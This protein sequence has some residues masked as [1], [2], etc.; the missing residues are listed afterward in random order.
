MAAVPRL[1]TAI[2]PEELRG[3]VTLVPVINE[4]AF[5]GGHRTA[6]DGLDLA[7]TCPGRPA[8]SITGQ[9]AFSLPHLI[10]AAYLY[11]DLHTGGTRLTV[12]P[13]SGY[14]L[15]RNDDVLAKQR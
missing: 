2:K 8:G 7:R 14:M 1:M 3:R 10:R 11:I 13:L 4:P 5:R 9:I 12:Q 15:H 6:E